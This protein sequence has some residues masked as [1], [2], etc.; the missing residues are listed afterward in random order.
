LLA[1]GG[2]LQ[3]YFYKS[4]LQPTLPK[5]SLKR[6]DSA[7]LRGMVPWLRAK[8]IAFLFNFASETNLD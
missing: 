3:G 8:S 6:E 4:I 2:G 1:C 7:A 5:N